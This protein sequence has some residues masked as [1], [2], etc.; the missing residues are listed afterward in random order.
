MDDEIIIYLFPYS[1]NHHYFVSAPPHKR[2]Q[3]RDE[4]RLFVFSL[5]NCSSENDGVPITLFLAFLNTPNQNFI[6]WFIV[7]GTSWFGVH[8][9]CKCFNLNIIILCRIRCKNPILMIKKSLDFARDPAI[10]FLGKRLTPEYPAMVLKGNRR[11]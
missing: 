8:S 4:Y 7:Y 11:K 2:K 9:L 5:L 6:S 1:N 10:I 3:L